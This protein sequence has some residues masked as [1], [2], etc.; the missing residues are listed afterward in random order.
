MPKFITNNIQISSDDCD[1]ED[2]IEENSDKENSD[3]KNF[4]EENKVQNVKKKT[5]AE[6][7]KAIHKKLI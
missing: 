7:L 1:R 6:L 3:D 5:T 4:N 2:S